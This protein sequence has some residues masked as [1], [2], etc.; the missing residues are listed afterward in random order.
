MKVLT[1]NN[2]NG[3]VSIRE[4]PIPALPDGFV[5]VK[6]IFS[7]VSMGTESASVE[8]A[9]KNLL[10]K[11]R[12]RP[13]DF[14][15]VLALV[16]RVGVCEAYKL[17]MSK[18]ELPSP[19]G[20]SSAGIIVKISPGVRG[21]KVGDAVA[22][23]GCGHAEL[24]SVPENLC[25]K[26]PDGVSFKDA[27]YTTIASIALQGVRQSRATIGESVLVIGLGLIGQITMKILAASGCKT[28]GTDIEEANIKLSKKLG[29][30]ASIRSESN[31]T[32][33]LMQ[34]TD[35][36]GFDSVIITA[37]TKSNDPLSF[38]TDCV[39]DRGNITVVGDVKLELSRKKFYEK[40]LSLILSR[41]Y[42]A[43]RYEKNYEEKGYDYPI[44]Y[45]RWTE[46][47]NMQSV[48]D[49]LQRKL[50]KFTDLNPIVKKFEESA[51]LYDDLKSPGKKYLSALIEYSS[52]DEIKLN[53]TQIFNK[54]SSSAKISVGL[55]GAGNYA[56]TALLPL[57]TSSEKVMLK[58][59]VTQ[60]GSTGKFLS[61]KY[62][63]QY[64]TTKP[65]RLLDD[66]NLDLVFVLTRHDSHSKYVINCLERNINVFVEKPLATNMNDLVKIGE[67]YSKSRASIMV[68][69]NRRFSPLVKKMKSYSSKR[70]SPVYLNYSINAGHLDSNHWL[71]DINEGG[72]RLVGEACHFLDLSNYLIDKTLLSSDIDFLPL[73]SGK[74]KDDSFLLK[75]MYSDGSLSTISY[76]SESSTCLPKEKIEMS[77]GGI[78]LVMDDFSSLKVFSDKGNVENIRIT[79]DKGQKLMI[80][81]L[82][83]SHLDDSIGLPDFDLMFNVFQTLIT[84]RDTK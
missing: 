32:N 80:E 73:S 68:G 7:S 16:D 42:G 35:G 58:G 74:P 45:V 5:L 8:I 21:L 50:F 14:K 38:A 22:C 52:I 70:K 31:L 23:G 59:L 54:K 9:K 27:S 69:F 1:K 81:S 30:N 11:A 10:E 41:S 61:E 34:F 71:H 36:K 55:I 33:K 79:Q 26:I 40:E 56:Q 29:F 60:N 77:F 75:S 24:V 78:T 51:S 4:A 18:L 13:D 19:L 25:S 53:R 48:L 83:S 20:Y 82:I 15:K 39:R 28:F 43:G 63:F 62:N 17:S 72:G 84:L 37:S 76:L 3:E 66:D 49:M 67:I 64:I 46:N 47:R 12:S 44:G 65:E 57:L 2:A 6:N